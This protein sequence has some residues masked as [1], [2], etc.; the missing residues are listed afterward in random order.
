[1]F[2]LLGEIVFETLDSPTGYESR[3]AFRYAQQRVLQ[4]RPRL[5]WVA[6][7]LEAIDL[8]IQLHSSFTNPDLE[9]FA[10]EVA[11]AD[12]LARPLVFGNGN[13]RGLF[14]LV[15]LEFAARQMSAIGDLISV[16]ARL[17]LMEFD[18]ISGLGAA[19]L[20]GGLPALG[21]IGA[22]PGAPTAPMSYTAP[23]GVASALA[24]PAAAFTSAPLLAPGVSPLLSLPASAGAA[25][26]R[27]MAA[28]VPTSQIVRGAA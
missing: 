25:G 13:F 26:P 11:A 8:E 14:V 5:Q 23:G 15:S 9:I 3:R 12:H 18:S 1:M 20:F 28:D 27:L 22:A 24:A 19:S 10:L 6:D 2:A 7:G 17:G 16:S 21:A 4:A